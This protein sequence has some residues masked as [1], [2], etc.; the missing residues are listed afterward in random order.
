MAKGGGRAKCGMYRAFRASTKLKICMPKRT[1]SSFFFLCSSELASR[2]SVINYRH[3]IILVYRAGVVGDCLSYET[4]PLP[5]APGSRPPGRTVSI[6]C[7]PRRM[8]GHEG[9]WQGQGRNY[10]CSFVFA[11]GWGRAQKVFEKRCQRIRS[12]HLRICSHT[13][14]TWSGTRGRVFIPAEIRT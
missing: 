11:C 9:S 1:N 12:V 7:R 10:W 14:V 13:N 6:R 4:H 3:Y 5:P 2:S 8:G